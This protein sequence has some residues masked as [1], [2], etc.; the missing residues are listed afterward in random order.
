MDRHGLK[1]ERSKLHE[2]F[3]TVL[4]QSPLY[5]ST[6]WHLKAYIL[7]QKELP[8]VEILYRGFFWPQIT[9]QN[10]QHTDEICNTQTD[11]ATHRHESTNFD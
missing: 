9:D 6:V 11:S 2:D 7:S 8:D 4:S 1:A 3:E 5:V 10:M